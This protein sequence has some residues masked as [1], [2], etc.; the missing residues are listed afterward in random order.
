M[1]RPAQCHD[2]LINE[3]HIWVWAEGPPG[4]G[5]KATESAKL[6]EPKCGLRLSYP[7]LGKQEGRGSS[8]LFPEAEAHQGNFGIPICI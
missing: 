7:L 8:F 1:N 3:P 4:L 5:P 2:H 6:A